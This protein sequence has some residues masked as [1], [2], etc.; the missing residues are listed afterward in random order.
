LYRNSIKSIAPFVVLLSFIFC[1]FIPAAQAGE[2]VARHLALNEALFTVVDGGALFSL[3]GEP[4][5]TL[6]EKIDMCPGDVYLFEAAGADGLIWHSGNTSAATVDGGTVTAVSEG[7]AVITVLKPDGGESSCTVYVKKCSISSEGYITADGLLRGIGKNTYAN[8]LL[9]GIDADE[10]DLKLYNGDSLFTGDDKVLC[11]GMTAELVIGGVPRDRLTIIVEGDVNGDGK[12]DISDYTLIRLD[13]LKLK[14]LKDI[15]KAAADV[16]MDGEIT[17]SDYTLIRLNILG[18]KRVGGFMP[19]LPAIANKKITTFIEAAFAQMGAPYVSGRE[20][21]AQ[22]DCSGLVYYCLNKAGHKIGRCS[23][24]TYSKY[25][26]WK[27]VEKE[28]LSPGDLMFFWS[29]D[30]SKIGHVGIYLGNNYFIHSTATYKGVV[31]SRFDGKYEA[32]FSHGRR[33]FN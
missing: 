29:S 26:Y 22:Y 1:I 7:S 10:N 24:N 18:L 25:P 8:H 31:I 6:P 4:E 21:P 17:I 2:S 27:L 11:T 5:I 16:D 15:Y 9:A 23:A 32:S 30:L 33:V 13:I 20:G 19:R 14:E 12:V 3:S 28:N